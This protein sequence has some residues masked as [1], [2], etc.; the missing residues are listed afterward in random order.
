MKKH[1]PFLF[2]GLFCFAMN[3]LAQSPYFFKTTEALKTEKAAALQSAQYTVSNDITKELDARSEAQKKIESIQADINKK[4]EIE[5]Y[6]AAQ[7][8]KDEMDKIK[9]N[10]AKADDLRKKIEASLAIEDYEKAEQY[11]N[12]LIGVNNPTQ[13][14]AVKQE[15]K[16][17]ETP[18]Q[19]DGFSSQYNSNT[20]SNQALINSLS[21]TGSGMAAFIAG[22]NTTAAPKSSNQLSYDEL[23]KRCNKYKRRGIFSTIFGPICLVTGVTLFS[24]GI[25]NTSY[26]YYDGYYTTDPLPE[27]MIPGVVLMT[28]GMIHTIGGPAMLG[29]SRYYRKK[30]NNQ[31]SGTSFL[32]I[33]SPVYNNYNQSWGINAGVGVKCVF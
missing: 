13:V 18:P 21:A 3:S 19:G 20:N 14:A 2:F 1:I 28:V 15:V 9:A 12:A 23:M 29:R 8:L 5:D 6:V 11:K 32:P 30:A 4:L 26:D 10:I 31:G 33:I 25:T 27:L 7:S 17:S 22:S 16:I 24:V